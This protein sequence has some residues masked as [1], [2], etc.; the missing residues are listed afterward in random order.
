MPEMTRYRAG[1]FCWADLATTDTEGAKSFYAGLFGWE[2]VDMPTD[3][4]VPYT[5]LMKDGK[6]AC[7]LYG[8][9]PEQ[10]VA[11]PHWQAYVSVKDANAVTAA[12]V[13]QGG[14]VLMAPMNV[15]EAG[16]MAVLQDPTGAVLGLWQARQHLGAQLWN[17]PGAICWNELLSRDPD[18]AERFF[19][20]LLGWTTRTSAR[21]MEGKYRILLNGEEQVGGLLQIEPGWG[22][23][24]SRW[25]VYFGVDDCDR[26]ISTA[27]GQGG[28]L[29]FPAM[30]I[31]NVGRFAYL[32]DP[33]GALFAIIQHP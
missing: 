23:M 33:Q 1:S 25:T 27:E 13:D 26:A 29:L 7:A 8:M 16:R 19:G 32:M 2:P 18:R 20:G 17:Q 11:P 12:V 28:R 30:E 31:E 15:M 4:G 24:P 3:G 21:V 5:M 22:D 9:G 10:A 6:Q 14:N